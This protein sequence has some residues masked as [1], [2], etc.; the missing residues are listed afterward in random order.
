MGDEVRR[1]RKENVD[2]FAAC[3]WKSVS[4]VWG[5]KGKRSATDVSE[6]GRF[7]QRSRK[8]K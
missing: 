7:F 4:V 3:T 6:A 5:K 2:Q 8:S 1:T